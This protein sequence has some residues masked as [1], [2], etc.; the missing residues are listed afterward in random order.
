MGKRNRRLAKTRQQTSASQARWNI[1]FW[2]FMVAA[3]IV[4]VVLYIAIGKRAEE[5]KDAAVTSHSPVA[6]AV[7]P[8]F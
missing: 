1:A 4:A 3:L 7:E 5:S 2:C 8:N 6:T